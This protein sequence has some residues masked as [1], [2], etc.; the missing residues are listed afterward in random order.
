VPISIKDMICEEGEGLTCGSTWLGA[1]YVA[2][3]DA[4]VVSMLKQ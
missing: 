3:K 2:E 4:P 1:H